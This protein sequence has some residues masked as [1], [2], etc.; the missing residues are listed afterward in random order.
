MVSRQSCP[1]SFALASVGGKE[2]KLGG[3]LVEK[4]KIKSKRLG[5]D[6][7]AVEQ[8]FGTLVNKKYEFLVM[9]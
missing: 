3:T 8:K 4:K 5:Q 6:G 9:L 1:S 2:K 7:K